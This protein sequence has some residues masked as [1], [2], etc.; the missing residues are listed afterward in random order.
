MLLKKLILILIFILS[1]NYTTVTPSHAAALNSNTIKELKK[2]KKLAKK[3]K[4]L[5]SGSLKLNSPYEKFYQKF[6]KPVYT[7]TP[8]GAV[9]E[10]HF[11]NGTVIYTNG[12]Y[13]FRKGTLK[14][15]KNDPVKNI[16][17][18]YKVDYKHIKKVFGNKK[19]LSYASGDYFISYRVGKND[20]LFS[21]GENGP[22]NG[23]LNLYNNTLFY[24]Y[25]IVN[26]N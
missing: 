18:Y 7:F 8:K 20:V 25:A 3:G 14:R 1:F 12:N 10:D 15:V 19:S 23:S 6:G 21:L 16:T 24:D 5:N 13:N 4:T 17:M 11:S 26:W 2:I 9:F 22:W